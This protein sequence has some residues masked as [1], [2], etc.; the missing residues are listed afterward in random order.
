M[1]RISY[2]R[3]EDSMRFKA[4]VL[5]TVISIVTVQIGYDP[6]DPTL[7]DETTTTTSAIVGGADTTIEQHP[8]QVTLLV[9]GF[10]HWCGGS[11]L[12]PDWVLTAAHCVAQ[13]EPS[14]VT[15]Q[16]GIT[17]LSQNNGQVI[18]VSNIILYPGY[19]AP[20][21]SRDLALLR[22]STPLDLSGP[23][24]SAIGIVRGRYEIV[25][26]LE[27]GVEALV[28][29]WGDLSSGGL[30]SDT[31]QVAE[32][33][34]IS[35]AVAEQPYKISAP[36]ITITDDQ[37]AAG[38]LN[39]GQDACQGDSGGPLTMV[40]GNGTRRLAGVVSW[41]V[42]CGDPQFPGMYTR[43]GYFGWWI[44]AYTSFETPPAEFLT[45]ADGGD[46]N[47]AGDL[48]GTSLAAGD[49]DGGG[50]E[51]L[52]IG[53]PGE[54]PGSDPQSGAIFIFVGMPPGFIATGG[55][56][57]TARGKILTQADAWAANE[58]GDLFGH[59]AAAGDFN[60]D[61]YDDLI[62]GGP[63]ESP[64]AEPQAGAVFVF[65]GS[66]IIRLTTGHVL[67]QGDAQGLNEAGDQFGWSLAV[68]DLVATAS[69]TWSLEAQA[70]LRAPTQN[71]ALSSSPWAL[72]AGLPMVSRS[73]RR[74][75]IE[76]VLQEPP[77][78]RHPV[79]LEQILRL[80][81]GQPV[82]L[83][84]AQRRHNVLESNPRIHE[85][86]CCSSTCDVVPE[87]ALGSYV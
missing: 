44:N 60:G 51:D 75:K 54:S 87:W 85:V 26:M 27:P 32:V 5:P 3:P 79:G 83:L 34:V 55:D 43:V 72:R 48:F 35:N 66:P 23:R 50:S 9:P 65:D 14:Q 68:G 2:L 61:G 36:N 74:S 24:A 38:M 59:S 56:G 15:V 77:Q 31:L 22:L 82:H 63:G 80:P 33:P 10:N 76:V 21:R 6:K 78:Q 52:V 46:V 13:F 1:K 70:S 16:A 53:P 29:G 71:Q 73:S 84:R 18:G 58:D 81:V 28:A 39:G 17:R 47:E 7:S 86:L 41:G 45:P 62:V 57:R 64:G 40:D 4:I 49:F 69:K 30:S 67:T 12:R 25:G 37:L 20:S 11:I 8:W 19:V 42:G